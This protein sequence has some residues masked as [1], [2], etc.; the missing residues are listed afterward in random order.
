MFDVIVSCEQLQTVMIFYLQSFVPTSYEYGFG[1]HES[2]LNF[3]SQIFPCLQRMLS[4]EELFY[5]NVC[6]RLP[7]VQTLPS[8]LCVH[9]MVF[10]PDE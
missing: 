6:A 10:I 2:P 8:F 7:F 3:I 5:K 9:I 1:D 4:V